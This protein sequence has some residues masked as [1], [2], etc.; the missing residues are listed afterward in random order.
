VE[1]EYQGVRRSC[2]PNCLLGF[3]TS[4][5]LFDI[6]FHHMGS[7][8]VY[9]VPLTMLET[10]VFIMIVPPLFLTVSL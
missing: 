1:R 10:F 2:G 8:A 5:D 9:S 4:L 6:D 3:I 7:E